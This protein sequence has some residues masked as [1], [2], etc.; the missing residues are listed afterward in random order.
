MAGQFYGPRVKQAGLACL[1][2]LVLFLLLP[3]GTQAQ[4]TSALEKEIFSLDG[5]RVKL[6]LEKASAAEDGRRKDLRQAA[7]LYCEAASYGSL[8]GEYRLARIILNDRDSPESS[9]ARDKLQMAATLFRN[10]A[11]NGHEGAQ[12]MI[13]ITGEQAERLPECLTKAAARHSL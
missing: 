10:A 8:E 9:S 1:P 12:A 6:M 4:S 13:L 3:L 5:A 7:A 11:G 2:L